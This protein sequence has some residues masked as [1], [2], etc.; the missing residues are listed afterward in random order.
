MQLHL[1]EPSPCWWNIPAVSR[2]LQHRDPAVPPWFWQ[3]DAL[4]LMRAFPFS[5][6]KAFVGKEQ[7]GIPL[8]EGDELLGSEKGL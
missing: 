4:G 5:L 1:S 2:D 7:E 6:S 3:D 8:E